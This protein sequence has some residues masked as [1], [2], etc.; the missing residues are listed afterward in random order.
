MTSYKIGQDEQFAFK[1]V[2]SR[3]VEMTSL[4]YRQNEQWTPLSPNVRKWEGRQFGQAKIRSST[5]LSKPDPDHHHLEGDFAAEA[6]YIH[7]NSQG[8]RPAAPRVSS[9]HVWGVR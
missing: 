4:G 2:L 3:L 5:S 1:R 6:S 9:D 7:S 8:G